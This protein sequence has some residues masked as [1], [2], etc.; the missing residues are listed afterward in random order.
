[1]NRFD[2]FVKLFQ[3]CKEITTFLASLI[4]IIS[5]IFKLIGIF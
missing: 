1:M 3:I 4:A 5:F 2:K